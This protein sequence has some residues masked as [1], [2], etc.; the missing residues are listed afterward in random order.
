MSQTAYSPNYE[1]KLV[2]QDDHAWQLELMAK[3][4]D[5]VEFARLRM[6]VDKTAHQPIKI[7]YLEANGK[8]LKTEE[9]SDYQRDNAQHIGPRR[10]VV[11][12]HRRNDHSSE[13][14]FTGVKLNQ[15]LKDELFTQ[16]SL[17]R[18]N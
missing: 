12:D 2:G 13:I 10:V 1:A 15:G 3:R 18:G 11:T 7:E 14:I 9:R 5:A 8:K 16:R 6:W 4:S 17:I